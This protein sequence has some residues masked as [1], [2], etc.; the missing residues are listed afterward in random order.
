[1]LSRGQSDFEWYHQRTDAI[2][3]SLDPDRLSRTASAAPSEPSTTMSAESMIP[4]DAIADS[5]PSLVDVEASANG[6]EIDS[7][8][9]SEHDSDELT[10]SIEESES[11]AEREWKESLEQL[12]MVLS[13]VIIPAAG[14]YF[15]RRFAYWGWKQFM[16]WKYPVEIKITN[17]GAFRAAGIVESVATL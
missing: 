16:E 17:K 6:D 2:S 3:T 9:S 5:Q 12:E 8:P 10:I 14:K 13:M 15:G 11:D 7:L 4:P 1:M